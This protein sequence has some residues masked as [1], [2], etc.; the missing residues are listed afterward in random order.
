MMSIEK[1]EK[2]SKWRVEAALRTLL[3]AE[4]IRAD[5]KMMGLVEKEKMREMG[6]LKGLR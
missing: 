6:L 5:K 1:Q 3:E 2:Y 4:E